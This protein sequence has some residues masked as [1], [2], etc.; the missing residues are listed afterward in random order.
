MSIIANI[1]L[2]ELKAK[3]TRILRNTIELKKSTGCLSSDE[4]SLGLKTRGEGITQ[5]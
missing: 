2:N 3:A 1:R 4:D 5:V